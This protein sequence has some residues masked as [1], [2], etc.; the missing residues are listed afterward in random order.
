MEIWKACPQGLEGMALSACSTGRGKEV[1]EG[2]TV[3][4]A[5]EASESC[6]PLL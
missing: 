2:N 3:G 5:Q 4:G 1:G 6:E